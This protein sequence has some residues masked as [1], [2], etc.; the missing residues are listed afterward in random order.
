MMSGWRGGSSLWVAGFRNFE[1]WVKLRPC[2]SVQAQGGK[3]DG[4]V[5]IE[6]LAD[7]HL[8]EKG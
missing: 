8:S 7:N 2:S 6:W 3:K 4:T 1:V 5:L